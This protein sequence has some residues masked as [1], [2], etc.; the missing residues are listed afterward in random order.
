[1]K[2]LLQRVSRA[3]VRIEGKVVG[4][5]DRG[6]LLLVGFGHMDDTDV[7]L[8]MANKLANLRVFPDEQGR[9]QYSLLDIEGAALLVPQ[10]TLY[11]DTKKGRRPDFTRS[12]KPEAAAGLFE[13]FVAVVRSSG[14]QKVESGRFG[15]DMQV[16]LVNDG[17]VTILVS[18][19]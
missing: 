16:E 19:E 12:M 7:L 9:F 6:L 2:I 14:V 11:A 13:E 1:M 3:S 17:P 10:F 8:P 15:A 18:S 5:I 4:A